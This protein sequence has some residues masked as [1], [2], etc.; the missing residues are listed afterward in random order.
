MTKKHFV[1]IARIINGVT[2]HEYGTC[3]GRR[4]AIEIAERLATFFSTL[5]THF[6]RAVFMAAAIPE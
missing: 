3:D 5:N 1:E 4:V 6:D 2:P